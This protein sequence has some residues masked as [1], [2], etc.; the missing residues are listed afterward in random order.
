M[1][2]KIIHQTWKNDKI[3]SE[4]KG[5]VKKLKKL[6]PDWSYRLWTDDDCLTFVE[7]EFPDFIETYKGFSKNIMRADV[8]RYLIMYKIGG[9]YL[10]LDYEVL[11][12]FDFGEHR[13][14]LPYNRQKEFGDNY[15][16]IGNCIFASEP[17][18]PFWRDVIDQLKLGLRKD[19]Q[20]LHPDSTI[21]TETT[22]PEFLTGVYFQKAYPDINT[23]N[24]MVYHPPNPLSKK[25]AK[26]IKRNGVSL[27]IHYCW[28]SW[29]PQSNLKR[30]LKHSARQLNLMRII[31]FLG[32][33]KKT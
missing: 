28:G 3:P 22:G 7:E 12:P 15:D 14:V 17:G 23:P 13:V 2:P 20:K 6:N 10:D 26:E 29:R 1:I 30:F 33:T 4:W 16:G 19:F 25:E 21:E 9:V 11:K 8:I 18:H 5:F 31:H 27:G 24:R 32:F